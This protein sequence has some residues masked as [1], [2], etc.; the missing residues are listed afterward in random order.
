MVKAWKG[1]ACV[2][3]ITQ[4][5]RGLA[6]LAGYIA[7]RENLCKSVGQCRISGLHTFSFGCHSNGGSYS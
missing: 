6:P 3:V 1:K 5:A 4:F 2:I 7:D